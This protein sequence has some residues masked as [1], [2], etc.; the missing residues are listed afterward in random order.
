MNIDNLHSMTNEELIQAH[1]RDMGNRA[2]HYNIYLD[3]LTRRETRRHSTRM[4]ALTESINRLTRIITIA[5]IAGVLL[6]ALNIAF[7]AFGS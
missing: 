5:T 3:E 1:N 2:A 4:E 6:T 7:I